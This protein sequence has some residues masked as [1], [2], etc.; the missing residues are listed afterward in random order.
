MYE[1]S[2]NL[3][4]N[5]DNKKSL[6]R[7][8]RV[9][10]GL[11]ELHSGDKQGKFYIG[12][13]RAD[14]RHHALDAIVLACT[15]RSYLQKIATLMGEGHSLKELKEKN[16]FP[17]PWRNF[18]ADVRA[19]LYETLIVHPQPKQN[20][21]TF[22]RKYIKKDNKKYLAQGVTAK[23]ALHEESYYGCY[24]NKK[25]GDEEYR[26]RKPLES[27]TTLKQVQK[28][29]DEGVRR[30]V[31][32]RLQEIGIDT[33]NPETDFSKVKNVFFEFDE[34]GRKIPKVFMPNKK[35]KPVP[36]K[37]VRIAENLSTP[38]RMPGNVNRWVKPGKN[39]GVAIYQDKQ[40]KYHECVVTFW[41]AV[42]RQ[43]E[44]S[45]VFPDVEGYRLVLTLQ[46][47]ELFLLGLPP[48]KVEWNNPSQ[49]SAHLYRVQKLSSGDY[50]FRLHKA[51]T[52]DIPYEAIC[53]KS[54]EKFFAE[55]HPIKV[56][57]DVLGNITPV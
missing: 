56:T 47:N 30:Q 52:V 12:K 28:I 6:G 25:T 21:V 34:Q 5:K 9:V 46:Q 55:Q 4:D 37:K 17:L 26:K 42:K 33:S 32:L 38:I 14:H 20:V 39:Y 19:A 1:W 8:G 15:Q 16:L 41:E 50:Y 36:V 44:N 53:I 27:I 49:L 10:Q 45:K 57:L 22:S 51:A 31:I 54:L 11:V 29:V 43:K 3:E 18:R 23:G 48:D 40:G 24:K 13:N 7:L 2:A 35:G